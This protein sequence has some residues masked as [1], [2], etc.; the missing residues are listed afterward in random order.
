MPGPQVHSHWLVHGAGANTTPHVREA[1][2]MTFYEG[3]ARIDDRFVDWGGGEGAV[4]RMLGSRRHGELADSPRN[5][6]LFSRT[7]KQ[8]NTA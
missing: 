3:S 1:F 8:R 2:A 5:P 7:A 4:D 6:L